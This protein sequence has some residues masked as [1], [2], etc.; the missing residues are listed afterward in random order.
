MQGPLAETPH[1]TATSAPGAHGDRPGAARGGPII[2]LEA[3]KFPAARVLVVDDEGLLRWSL[4]EMLHAAGYQVL[5]ARDGREARLAFAD[6]A[7]P[8]DAIL[9]DLKLPDVYGL[10]LIQEARRHCAGCPIVIMTAYGTADVVEA[11]LSAGAAR[12]LTKPFD[13]DLMVGLLRELCPA[14]CH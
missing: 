9:L 12:V 14:R 11:A 8:L 3:A 1:S 5:Q 6:D 4:S 2:P 7:H 13:L 10:Q